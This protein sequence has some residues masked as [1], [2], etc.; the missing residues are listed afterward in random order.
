MEQLVKL[1]KILEKRIKENQLSWET[2]WGLSEAIIEIK[3]LENE[4]YC[5]S[6]TEAGY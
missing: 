2:N 3:R 6:L 5:Q 4:F 1:K